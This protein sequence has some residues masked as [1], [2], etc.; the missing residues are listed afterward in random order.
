MARINE[1]IL[2]QKHRYEHVDTYRF[3]SDR[4]DQAWAR[5]RALVRPLRSRYSSICLSWWLRVRLAWSDWGRGISWADFRSPS[6]CRRVCGTCHAIHA[7]SALWDFGHRTASCRWP[8]C[9]RWRPSST[10][11]LRGRRTFCLGKVFATK[12]KKKLFI[13]RTLFFFFFERNTG[14]IV[15]FSHEILN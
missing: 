12:E 7:L 11:P 5:C 4:W 10:R 2:E 15:H 9:T 1:A 3:C 13:W 6:T 8:A 14:S